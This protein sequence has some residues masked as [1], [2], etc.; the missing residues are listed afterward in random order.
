MLSPLQAEVPCSFSFS[1]SLSSL[2][3]GSSNKKSEHVHT[4][5]YVMPCTDVWNSFKYRVIAGRC[6]GQGKFDFF[7]HNYPSLSVSEDFLNQHI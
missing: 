6:Q 5:L 7:A 2:S 3:V 1:F 4:A